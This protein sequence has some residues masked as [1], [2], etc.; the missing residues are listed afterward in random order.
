[1]ARK[2]VDELQNV[3]NS[4]NFLYYT[5]DKKENLYCNNGR[6]IFTFIILCLLLQHIISFPHNT[7]MWSTR[8]WSAQ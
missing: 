3:D 8:K 6:R 4:H 5:T 1:M 7:K 2:Q